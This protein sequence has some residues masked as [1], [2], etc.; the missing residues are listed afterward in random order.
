MFH[1]KNARHADYWISQS[2]PVIRV[3]RTS[4]GNIRLMDVSLYLRN[5]VD[6]N[7]RKART[8]VFQGEPFT[9][10]NLQRVRDKFIPPP[11]Q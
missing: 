1:I 11:R 6:K 4:N 8:V 2:Y 10:L 7:R 5:E 9:A 3:I